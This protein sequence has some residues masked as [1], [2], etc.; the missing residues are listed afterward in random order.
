MLG[1]CVSELGI[2]KPIGTQFSNSL[3]SYLD[4]IWSVPC[5]TFH[6]HCNNGGTPSEDLRVWK[7][8]D[9]YKS[10]NTPEVSVVETLGIHVISFVALFLVPNYLSPSLNW[11]SPLS[12]QIRLILQEGSGNRYG[13]I[14]EFYA[15]FSIFPQT[16]QKYFHNFVLF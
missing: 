14:I 5:L 10:D 3:A 15:S 11:E 8:L 7:R 13:N 6:F 16:C 12:D 2:F 4:Y 1:T 9:T